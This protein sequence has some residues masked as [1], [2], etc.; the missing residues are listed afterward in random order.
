LENWLGLRLLKKFRKE[1]FKLWG[2]PNFNSPK[3]ERL[4]W[5]GETNLEGR[6]LGRKRLLGVAILS[7]VQLG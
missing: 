5:L 4:D 1:G 6:I 3:K 7:W 2:W